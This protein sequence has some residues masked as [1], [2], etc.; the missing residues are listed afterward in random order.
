MIINPDYSVYLGFSRLLCIVDQSLINFP[1]LERPRNFC[2]QL[3][4]YPI[5]MKC[6]LRQLVCF[7]PVFFDCQ[8]I[9]CMEDVCHADQ[10]FQTL[11]ANLIHH[12]AVA[13]WTI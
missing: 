4:V 5:H 9:F 1:H 11:S 12:I 10:M 6:P 13:P 3:R 2:Y 8:G 7:Y